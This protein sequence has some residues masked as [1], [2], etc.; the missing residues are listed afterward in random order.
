VEFEG[1]HRSVLALLDTLDSGNDYHALQQESLKCYTVCN[2][3]KLAVWSRPVKYRPS[4]PQTD[5]RLLFR[6]LNN[7]VGVVDLRTKKWIWS[8]TLPTPLGT[9]TMIPVSGGEG[10]SGPLLLKV[11]YAGEVSYLPLGERSFELY[12]PEGFA[13]RIRYLHEQRMIAISIEGPQKR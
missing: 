9:L 5:V 6:P 3:T 4:A 2:R 11:T 13:P 1:I 8:F 10:E 7:P 12:F